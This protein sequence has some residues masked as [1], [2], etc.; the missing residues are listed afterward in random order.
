MTPTYTYERQFKSISPKYNFKSPNPN[1][2]KLLY[3]YEGYPTL[4]LMGDSHSEHLY[5]GLKDLEDAK[6]LRVIKKNWGECSP[7]V[8]DISKNKCQIE[9]EET[10]KNIIT[11]KPDIVVL[12]AHWG[13]AKA[14]LSAI[15]DSLAFLKNIGIKRVIIIGQVPWW[16]KLLPIIVYKEFMKNRNNNL[17][18]KI[19]QRI[20]LLDSILSRAQKAD[21]YLKDL[22]DK[23]QYEFISVIDTLCNSD[24]CL[25]RLGDR[26]G[27][28]MQTDES[29]FSH[30]G[31]RYFIN[32]VKEYI[33]K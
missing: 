28:V 30:K 26:A 11:L 21:F 17:D 9:I 23:Y 20:K 18:L 31:A 2:W 4:L 5:P 8:H 19:P 27:D 13:A 24:G 12:G 7:I 14:N 33:I 32:N 22:T 3:T 1:E 6:L 25:V 10:K 15:D 29:H 16:E